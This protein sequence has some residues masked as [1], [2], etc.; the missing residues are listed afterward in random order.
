[1]NGRFAATATLEEVSKT[2]KIGSGLNIKPRYNTIPSQAVI[3]VRQPEEASFSKSDKTKKLVYMNLVLGLIG[4]KVTI[5][6][7]HN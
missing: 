3:V 4:K 7:A 6:K 1:M 2:F 5:W